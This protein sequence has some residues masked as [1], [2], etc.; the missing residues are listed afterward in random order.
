MP[1]PSSAHS[2]S[3]YLSSKRRPASSFKADSGLGTIRRQRT[4]PR[5]WARPKFAFQLLE[6]VSTHTSP[7]FATFG[8]K[9]LVIKNALGGW[10]GKPLGRT[11]LMRK[12]PFSYGVDTRLMWECGK[13]FQYNGGD[14]M[15]NHIHACI[16]SIAYHDYLHRAYNRLSLTR[17]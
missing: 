2:S 12:V 13:W 1:R 15:V 9:I 17:D 6:R 7:L 3:K 8:W 11:S 10:L 4:I 14:N 16:Y 5:I